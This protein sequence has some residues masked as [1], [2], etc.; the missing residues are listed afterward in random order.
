MGRKV[1]AIDVDDVLANSTEAFRVLVND[2]LKVN[3]S[4]EDYRIRADYD[5]YYEEVWERNG[6]SDRVNYADFEAGMI[7]DQSHIEPHGDAKRTLEKLA[8]CYKVIIVTSRPVS[9]RKATEK[10]IERHFPNIFSAILFTEETHGKTKGQL[11]KEYGADWLIDDNVEHAQSALDE[12]IE[13]IL[14]GN[15]GWHH[16]APLHMHRRGTWKEVLEYFDG[17]G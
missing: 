11:C 9:W 6:L 1:I 12:N 5:R 4:P 17:R 8:Q 16:K 2:H 3:L 15:Y 13:V 10:W 7:E 14:F